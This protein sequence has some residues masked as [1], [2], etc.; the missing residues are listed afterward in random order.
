MKEIENPLIGEPKRPL[1][2][3]EKS[4][5]EVKNYY[6]TMLYMY[7]LAKRGGALTQEDLFEEHRLLTKGLGY[8]GFY[9]NSPIYIVDATHDFPTAE[10]VPILME[11]FLKKLQQKRDLIGLDPEENAFTVAAWSHA[12]MVNIHPFQDGNGRASR[13]M[14]NYI[15]MSY[16]YIP[17]DVPYDDR[18]NYYKILDNYYSSRDHKPLT[19]YIEQ[20]EKQ[21]LTRV[22]KYHELAARK[23]EKATEK[24]KK[25]IPER[26]AR[27][28]VKISPVVDHR[29]QMDF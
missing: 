14:M 10:E 18:F 16:D 5:I 29:N 24:D 22:E 15:L 20:L 13:A 26:M 4:K 1:G 23:R 12:E 28:A 11:S 19:L 21:E 27:N 2:E 3:E 17:V 8:G 9:R 6:E 25:A 7:K